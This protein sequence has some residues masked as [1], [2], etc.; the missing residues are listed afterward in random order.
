MASSPEFDLVI[1]NA[2]LVDGSGG[3]RRQADIAIQ[4]STIAAVEGQGE[5]ARAN[6]G[7]VIDATDLVVTPGFVDIHTHYDGQVTWDPYLS[8][9]CYHGVT[10]VVMGNCGVGFA[11]VRPDKRGWLVELMEG[12][13]DIPGAAL[14]EG[15]RWGWETFPEYLDFLDSQPRTIDVGGQI[16]HGPVRAYVMGERGARNEPATPADIAE[17]A[18]IVRDAV[19]RG[20]LGFSTSRT[21]LHKALNG[22]PVPGTFASED[23]LIGICQAL[24]DLGKGVF[25]VSPSG[26]AGENDAAFPEEIDLLRRIGKAIERPIAFNL[27]QTSGAPE[28]YREL[29]SKCAAAAADGVQLVGVIAGRSSG[30]LFGL[31]TSYHPFATRPT[32]AA[33]ADL[34]LAARLAKLRDPAV[35]RA[36]L[37]EPDDPTRPSLLTR[38]ADKIWKLDDRLDYEPQPADSLAAAAARSGAEVTEVLYDW[39]VEGDGTQLFNVPMLNYA[40]HNSDAVHEMIQHD[41]TALGLTDGGAH[42]A[43][44]CDASI[45]TSMITHWTRDRTRGPRL[46]LEFIVNK[47]SRQTAALYSMHD[48]GLVAPGY[49]ADLNVFDYDRL[50]LLPPTVV[51]DLPGGARRIM[52]RA[53]G[54]RAT[55][56]SGQV[57][58]RD[59]EPTG[60]MPGRV[61]RS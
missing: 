51:R 8:P 38:V 39:M 25:E 16:G 22:E 33:L 11:P 57:T 10:T 48:R 23:E 28:L 15:L 21:L 45:P 37:A 1:T 53:E 31:E 32:F 50:R 5:L 14:K 61:V 7:E 49:K 9:S 2:T 40:R 12:V 27:T 60:A 29:L 34:P 20:A 18:A 30:M 54:Y 52:Q 56:V 24:R 3:P 4:G 59:G 6:G 43:L 41:C 35:R 36:I 17:M 42:V 26:V 46:P 44:I 58:F 55:I 47:Q 19:A 13:E